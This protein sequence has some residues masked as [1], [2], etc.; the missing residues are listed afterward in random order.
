MAISNKSDAYTFEQIINVNHL[1]KGTS[2]SRVIL[3][4][5]MFVDLNNGMNPYKSLNLNEYL[6][7]SSICEYFG[8]T[9]EEFEERTMS[10]T[11]ELQN[12]ECWLIKM[13]DR[14]KFT[15][16]EVTYYNG[17]LIYYYNG[18][19]IVIQNTSDFDEDDLSRHKYLSALTTRFLPSHIVNNY[20]NFVK[21]IQ[22]Y[23]RACDDG[24]YKIICNISDYSNIDKMP[25]DV[26]IL[27]VSQYAISFAPNIMEISYFYNKN[28]KEYL[29]DNI[30]SFLKIARKYLATKGTVQSI[31][32]LYDLIFNNEYNNNKNDLGKVDVILPYK[33][34]LY[35]SSYNSSLKYD[36]D[37]S[38]VVY[39][40]P[41]CISG[42][43]DAV[44]YRYDE[45]SKQYDNLTHIH[46]TDESDKDDL[47]NSTTYGYYTVILH[48]KLENP[49]QF[50]TM[51]EE[52]VKPTG[53]KII[54]K[55]KQKFEESEEFSYEFL[56]VNDEYDEYKIM[57][58]NIFS[59]G[60]NLFPDTQFCNTDFIEFRIK[61]FEK[62]VDGST[63]LLDRKSTR[64]NSS[65]AR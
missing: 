3:T 4:E 50:A 64:L 14:N 58:Y 23:L 15:Y 25:D 22:E 1:E 57:P 47:G 62:N 36:G 30:R 43:D 65:H 37:I 38:K 59:S 28:S 54:W 29:F 17:D 27:A 55:K 9:E 60:E 32:F 18:E 56:I 11:Y 2:S 39:S 6:D 53:V 51:F 20:P 44:V 35:L 16:N 12:Y 7:I 13:Y 52:L 34:M 26:L 40:Y 48:H 49:E 63:I 21:F 42:R 24:W 45:N 41:S 33:R 10:D 46:G 19:W 61:S 8:L 5:K 31:F